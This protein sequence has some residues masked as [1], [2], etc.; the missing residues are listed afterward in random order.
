ML[1][2]PVDKFP[3]CILCKGASTLHLLHTIPH[4]SARIPPLLQFQ[5]FKRSLHY[6]L[7]SRSPVLSYRL[8]EEPE[9]MWVANGS[10]LSITTFSPCNPFDLPPGVLQCLPNAAYSTQSSVEEKKIGMVTVHILYWT[11]VL[12]YVGRY[13]EIS[14]SS[15]AHLVHTLCSRILTNRRRN[16]MPRWLLALRFP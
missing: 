4:S 15:P 2:H 7:I 1:A 5:G 16:N 12:F 14:L 3:T 8:W 10:F 9:A 11:G 13:R 6:Y